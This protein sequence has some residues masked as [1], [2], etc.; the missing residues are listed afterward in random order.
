M[1]INSST[2]H[3]NLEEAPSPIR[4]YYTPNEVSRHNYAEDCWLSWLGK[5]YNLTPLL[6]KYEEDDELIKPI[7]AVAGTDISNWFHP[8]TGQVFHSKDFQ[9]R[10]RSL[11]LIFTL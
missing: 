11:R 8:Q 1:G 5:V 10:E 7:L 9:L 2:S 4:R 3:T 6:K